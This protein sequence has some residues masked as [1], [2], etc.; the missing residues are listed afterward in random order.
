MLSLEFWFTVAILILFLE[1]SVLLLILIAITG[2]LGFGSE[3]LRRKL[4]EWVPIGQGYV[5]K[6]RDLTR[7]VATKVVAPAISAR[8]QAAG[9]SHTVRV[10]FNRKS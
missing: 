9:L 3:I 7:Q 5:F 10:L 8:S 6:G 2:G 1:M 4:K